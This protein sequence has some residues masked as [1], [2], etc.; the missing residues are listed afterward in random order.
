MERTPLL[1]R[2]KRVSAALEWLKLNHID[3]YDLDISYK[4]LEQYPDHG[5]PV[6]V[7]Y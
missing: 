6:V 1:V 5:I 2:R 3:Y 7:A 4:N